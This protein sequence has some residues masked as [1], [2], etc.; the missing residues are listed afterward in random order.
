VDSPFS[1]GFKAPDK[2]PDRLLHVKDVNLG[3]G[4]KRI[5]NKV[6]MQILPSDRIGLIGPNGAGKSTLIK[7]LAG[8]LE[9]QGGTYW[10][11]QDLKIGYFAQHQLEQLNPNDSPL[12]HLRNLDKQAREQD[13][14]NYLGGFAFHGARVDEAIA[15]FSG[16][17]KARLALALL[18]Y[19]RPNLLLL[20]E[21]TNHLDL[22]MR[23]AL[24]MALQSFAGAMVIV[25]HDRHMLKTVT[26]KLILVDSGKAA[27]FEGDLD[28]Y[29][30]WL[31]NRF[32]QEELDSNP[33]QSTPANNAQSQ[34]ARKDQRRESA[35][36]RKR[37]Q[38]LKNKVD[39]LEKQ[40]EVLQQKKAQ[41]EEKLGDSELYSDAKKEVLKQVLLDKANVD[42]D[43]EVIEM[44]WMEV[45]EQYEIAQAED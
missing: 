24:S 9:P 14:R 39:K 1:F 37:L 29:S 35:E 10:Q 16:G 12:Q 26:D 42:N 43:L 27:E 19:Q 31:Q 6:E 2:L 25:S 21:P 23:L 34:T 36:K 33:S 15:P 30:V 3:Y 40:M 22:E 7:F 17:E 4:D 13:L 44:E 28:D 41:L 45:L 32:K 11:A 18:I 38:P 8:K 5:I 20:D